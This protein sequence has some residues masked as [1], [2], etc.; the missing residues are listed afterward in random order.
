IQG[1]NKTSTRF[2]LEPQRLFYANKELDF[3]VTAVAPVASEDNAPLDQY[4]LLPLSADPGKGIIGE[5]LTIIQHPGGERKQICVRENKLLKYA[6]NTLWYQTDTV[7]GSSG[8]PVFNQL[9]QVVAL[10][11]SGVPK[12]DDQGRWL[13]ID[14][15]VW[16]QSMDESQVAWIANE[17]I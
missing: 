3:A 14:G 9:W 13:T 10:H 12:T 16:D 4:G 2:A 15:R 1:R 5:Y 11:H 8:S 6:D 17:G 7:A